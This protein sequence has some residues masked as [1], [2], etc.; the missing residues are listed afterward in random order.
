MKYSI[1]DKVS[2]VLTLYAK[3]CGD[4][5][6]YGKNAKDVSERFIQ[7]S[8]LLPE[9]E[10]IG[11]Q[12]YCDNQS[13]YRSFVFSKEG[14]DITKDDLRWIF[15]DRKDVCESTQSEISDSLINH[16]KLY[17]LSTRKGNNEI[18]YQ[19][20]SIDFYKDVLAALKEFKAII[21]IVASVD[22][23]G[24]GL[25]LFSFPER[26]PL[27]IKTILSFAF[28][29]MDLKEAGNDCL[30]PES[31]K[32][33]SKL[34]A[35]GLQGLLEVFFYEKPVDVDLDEFEFDDF[36]IDEPECDTTEAQSKTS[37]EC[38]STSI[39]ELNLSVRAYN[40]LRRAGVHTIGQLK[41]MT[42]EDLTKVRN[43][44]KNA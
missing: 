3:N 19:K 15:R 7:I 38:D 10:Y 28:A 34:L 2:N 8:S 30:I 17:Y 6:D 22:S 37:D 1:T 20:E 27:R 44:G 39:E 4:F 32:I 29:D 35:F 23:A 5:Y 11:W 14:T 26:I 41:S 33:D 16:R 18:T 13:D 36:C 12:L 9:S 25:M 40:C 43:L 24:K 42:Y 31:A 21:R